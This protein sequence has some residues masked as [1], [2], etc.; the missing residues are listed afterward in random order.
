MCA[1]HVRPSAAEES[2]PIRLTM[3]DSDSPSDVVDALF[4]GRFASGE[5]PYARSRSV[6][7]VK[8]GLTLLPPGAKVLRSARDEDRSATSPRATASRCWCRG[9]TAART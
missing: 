5:Q 6:D 1:D 4:L 9:G 3:D 2:L 7:R 8:A